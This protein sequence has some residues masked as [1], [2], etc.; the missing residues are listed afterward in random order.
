VPRLLYPS[1]GGTA[2]A[3]ATFAWT[4]VPDAAAYEIQIAAQQDFA[5]T[6]VEDI[7]AGPGFVAELVVDEPLW[8]RVRALDRQGEQGPWSVVRRFRVA[9]PP[10]AQS[11][12][13]IVLRPTSVSGGEAVDLQVTLDQPAPAGGAAVTLS[14]SDPSLVTMPRRVLFRSGE[15]AAQ[16]SIK[17]KSVEGNAEVNI[18]ANST[19]EQRQATLRIGPP[20]PIPALAGV[21]M[22]PRYVAAGGQVDGMVTLAAPAPGK[23]EVRLASSDPSRVVVPPTVTISAGSN[24]AS[25]PVRSLHATTTGNVTITASL[26]GVVKSDAI[27]LTAAAGQEALPAPILLTPSYGAGGGGTSYG[28]AGEFTWSSVMGAASYTIEVSPVKTFDS[29]GNF[30]R[31]IPT[32]S[33]TITPLAAGRLWWRVRANDEKGAPGRWSTARPVGAR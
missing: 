5:E 26:D 1:E 10:P 16:V 14:A 12:R 32:T 22:H 9:P 15:T 17:A 4:R 33:V 30:S 27:E 29:P 23:M 21:A 18:L 25:F 13:G 7:T 20:R 8:W 3:W 31:T 24:G 28:L 6:Y 19:G 2:A 11:V